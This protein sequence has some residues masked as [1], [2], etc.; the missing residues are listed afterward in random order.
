MHRASVPF[1][2]KESQKPRPKVVI[3]HDLPAGKLE[4]KHS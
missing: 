3:C 4:E 2:E 1:V